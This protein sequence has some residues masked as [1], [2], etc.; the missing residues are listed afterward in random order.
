MMTERQLIERFL[1]LQEHPE[2]VTDEQLQQ[3]LADPQ[4]RELV[5][6][7]AFAKRALRNQQKSEEPDV[8]GEW[9]KFASRHSSND[10]SATKNHAPLVSIFSQLRKK[11][12]VFIGIL[13]VSGIAFA[14]IQIVRQRVGEHIETSVGGDLQSPTSVV[15]DL[16]PTQQVMPND[17][18]ETDT[19]EIP[20][21]MVFD[22]IRL[23]EI[24]PQIASY[25]QKEVKFRTENARQLR[26]YFVWKRED[27]LEHAIEKLNRFE[28]VSIKIEGNKIIVE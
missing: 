18:I 2:Q 13:L 25:Y 17:T 19:T 24:L 3:I 4:M 6:Q 28:R 23:D 15:R 10:T 20:Q 21:P 26:F 16:Q 5:K 1:E 27:G 12:A 22:N 14:A 7:M 11:V 9:E 8:D